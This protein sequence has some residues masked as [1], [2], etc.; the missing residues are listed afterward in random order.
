MNN[1]Y[2]KISI[3][4]PTLNQSEFIEDCIESVLS[5]EYPNLEY[6]ILDGGSTDD[7]LHI[8]AKYEEK[9]TFISQK[10]NGQVDAIN[11]GL[12]MCTGDIVRYL[13]SDDIYLPGALKRIGAHFSQ[14]PSSMA[15]TGKCKR[16][17]EA[18]NEINKGVSLY[19]NTWLHFLGFNSL[20]IQNYISQP[21]T[22]WKRELLTNIGYFDP[23]YHY[24]MDYDYWLRILKEH[25]M[26]FINFELAAFR[27]HKNSITGKTS[28]KH[29]EEDLSIAKIYA[30][31][32]I[33]CLHAILNK[34]A[35]FVFRRFYKRQDN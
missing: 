16:I 19:K 15:V 2:P 29:L 35:I 17:D 14:Y 9:L 31:Q 25:K 23:Q 18:G 3:I 4:T 6:I 21:A 22:F 33:F 8:V 1:Y 10:D 11:K 20:L 5:Q 30:P 28:Y 26:H 24:A 12:K 7:T 32:H 27:V 34:L 13:N